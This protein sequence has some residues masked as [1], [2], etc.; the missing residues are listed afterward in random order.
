MF[1][2]IHHAWGQ[3]NLEV[4]VHSSDH[5]VLPAAQVWIKGETTKHN[6]ITDSAGRCHFRLGNGSYIVNVHF[7]GFEES[8]DTVKAY[9]DVSLKV[10]LKHKSIQSQEVII[11][12]KQQD[13]NV[14]S[15]EIGT[16]TLTRKEILA[17]PKLMGESDALKAL[18]YTPGVALTGEGNSGLYVRGGANDQNL[19]LTDGA[20]VFN[21]AH[22]LG[23]FSVFNTDIINNVK[24]YKSSIPSTYGGRISSVLDIETLEGNYQKWEGSVS[25]GII[26]SKAFVTGP[27]WK[28]KANFYLSARK[29]YFSAL[30]YPVSRLIIKKSHLVFNGL[31]YGFYDMNAGFSLRLSARDNLQLKFYSGSDQFDLNREDVQLENSIDWGNRASS[32]HWKHLCDPGT[33]IDVLVTYSYYNFSLLSSQ[34][35]SSFHLSSDIDNVQG[36]AQLTRTLQNH[37]I[38]GG[39]QVS[40]LSTVPNNRS[41]TV[42]V[43]SLKYDYINRYRNYEYAAFINDE[44]DLGSKWK[45]NLGYRHSAY[46]QTGPYKNYVYDDS[47]TATDSSL[48]GKGQTVKW[49]H[50]PEIRTA[51]RY[52]INTNWSVKASFNTT[53]QYLNQVTASTVSLPSDFWIPSTPKVKPQYCRQAGIGAYR[54]FGD[55]AFE[56][57]VEVFYKE[58]DH[59]IEFNNSIFNTKE[60]KNW[61]DN[62]ISGRGKAFGAELFIKKSIGKTTGWLSYTFSRSFRYFAEINDGHRFPAKY[63]RIHDGSLVVT[64]TLNTKWTF[65]A[66]F[67]YA[68]G[69]AFT[70][71]VAR[72]IVQGNVLNEY[73]DYN[74]YRLPAYHRLDI[75]ATLRLKQTRKIRSE[76]NFSVYNVYNRQN[77]IFIFND[78]KGNLDKYELSVTPKQLSLLPVLPSVSWTFSF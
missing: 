10:V 67:V 38:K 64:H 35:N 70:V 62:L 63:D 52:L 34:S 49:Y 4:E 12:G 39:V 61:E 46:Q 7:L 14:K 19:V 3:N 37:L 22:L 56:T 69:E 9:Q 55:N 15:T 48:Y 50:H 5:N 31:G 45:I 17:M 26:S 78:M 47:G 18:Q 40:T 54:N 30:L 36:K 43:L 13:Q 44:M 8:T 11:H 76:I 27:V 77:P 6:A 60:I 25:L 1:L 74:G 53:A 72:Y 58:M 68:T 57:S 20:V 51:V 23:I 2:M 71:P 65:S 59:Q 66:V 16:T 32:L 24:L 41:A 29:C 73:G 33:I 21:S 28:D 75:S 42:D